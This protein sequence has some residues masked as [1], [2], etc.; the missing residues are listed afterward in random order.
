ML[1]DKVLDIVKSGE[2]WSLD[3]LAEQ[4]HGSLSSLRAILSFHGLGKGMYKG[5][6]PK[7]VR[8]HHKKSKAAA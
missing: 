5:V 8:N 1:A 7:K 6:K 3:S 2:V 4:T